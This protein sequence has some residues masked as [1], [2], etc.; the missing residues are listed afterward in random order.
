MIK[1]E[2]NDQPITDFKDKK[3]KK[4]LKCV[5]KRKTQYNTLCISIWQTLAAGSTAF[6]LSG[7]AL[8]SCFPVPLLSSCP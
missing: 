1:P 5:A 3:I 4:K 2:D 6:L 8:L 7:L